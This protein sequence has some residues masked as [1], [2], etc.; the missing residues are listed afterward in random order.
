MPVT[1]DNVPI[2]LD[3]DENFTPLSL[4][5]AINYY[6]Q[7]KKYVQLQETWTIRSYICELMMLI[8]SVHP[9]GYDNYRAMNEYIDHIGLKRFVEILNGGLC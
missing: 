8:D 4:E 3:L 2:P 7:F 1:I 9:K 5:V 6:P